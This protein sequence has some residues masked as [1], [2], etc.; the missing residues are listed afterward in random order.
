MFF[1]K[2]KLNGEDHVTQA[3]NIDELLRELNI[4]PERVAVEVNIEIV[5]KAD[6]GTKRLNNGDSV[7]I[8]SFVGGGQWM[9]NS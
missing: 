1:M 3:M 5:K 9:I 6:Y 8:V 2:I 4:V 7:E